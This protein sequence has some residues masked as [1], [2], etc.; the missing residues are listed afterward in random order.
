MKSCRERRRLPRDGRNEAVI[1]GETGGT[2]RRAPRADG[3]DAVPVFPES[4]FLIPEG[5][6]VPAAEIFVSARPAF[7]EIFTEEASD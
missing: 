3:S 7:D 1:D 2:A 4:Y 5:E 6:A